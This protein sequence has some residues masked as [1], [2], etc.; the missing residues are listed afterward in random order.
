MMQAGAKPIDLSKD[1]FCIHAL[2]DGDI[3]LILPTGRELA[4]LS[5]IYYSLNGEPWNKVNNVDNT[6]GLIITVSC[7]SGDRVYWKGN[8]TRLS[9]AGNKDAK[10]YGTA[11][12]ELE[13]NAM[14]L[15]YGDNFEDKV[16]FEDAA[17]FRNL[18]I[19]NTTLVSCEN[20]KLP[21]TTLVGDCYRTMF[22]DC[23]NL[24]TPLKKL[25]ASVIPTGAYYAMFQNSG[26]TTVPEMT[27]T[28][29][30][31]ESMGY[32]FHSSKVV[33]ASSIIIPAISS[34][35]EKACASMFY[36]AKSLKKAPILTSTTA[37]TRCYVSMFYQCTALEWVKMLVLDTASATACTNEWMRG[38]KNNAACVFVKH[39]NSVWTTTGASGVL[40][41]WKII[42][43]DPTEDKY[44]LDKAKATECDDHG[45][46]INA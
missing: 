5:K 28:R 16:A 32:M 19:G 13:G 3:S 11:Q 18:F 36:Q 42:Y 25:P 14:S 15:L 45:N 9:S 31:S 30:K 43:Y 24:I 21:A 33:D 10:F 17:V 27:P 44:Y 29:C 35:D 8:G 6:Q 2:S 37:A 23:T 20:L 26:I 22:K 7:S 41:N 34:S 39:I 1:W 38:A 4:N 40:A 46:V 12:H